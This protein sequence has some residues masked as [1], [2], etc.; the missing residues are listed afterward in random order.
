MV[1]KKSRINDARLND[2]AIRAV[3]RARLFDEHSHDNNAVILDEMGLLRGQVRVDL[4]VVNGQLHGYEI[5]SD[6]DSLRRLKQQ[7]MVYGGVFDQLTLVVG[8]RY[9]AEAFRVVPSWWGILHAVMLDNSVV[10]RELRA[11]SC[12]PNRDSRAIAELLWSAQALALLESRNAAR[13]MRGKSR[14]VLWDRISEQFHIDE[15]SAA[16]RE[17]IKARSVQ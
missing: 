4:A 11:P 15:I 2:S 7:V 1:V 17:G 14:C 13:G 3:L 9:A 16:V 10:L 6:R 12:N 5:K 8:D